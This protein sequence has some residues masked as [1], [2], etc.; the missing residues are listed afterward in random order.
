[1]GY[2]IMAGENIQ[3]AVYTPYGGALDLIYAHDPEVIIVGGAETG[4]T[5]AACWKI[6]LLCSKYPG[7]QYAIVRKTQKSIYSSVLQ[8]FK[9]VSAG[10]TAVP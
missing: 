7:A 6:H 3:G 4:K 5:A 8:T 10:A 9:K 1:M 2:T